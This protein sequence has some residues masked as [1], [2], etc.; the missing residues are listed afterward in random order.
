MVLSELGHQV[1]VTADADFDPDPA[2]ILWVYG[3]PNW[4]PR[5]F[6]C[7]RRCPPSERP[8]VLSWFSEPLPQ[9]RAAG[10]PRAR[11]HAREIAK[12]ILRDSRATDVYSNASRL[13]SLVRRDQLDLL[14]VSTPG[15]Q[16][17]LAERGIESSVVPLGYHRSK[18]GEDLEIERDLDVIFLGAMV[19]RRKKLLS[20]LRRSGIDVTAVGSWHDPALW[21]E[22]RTR[23]LSRTRIFL[24]LSRHPGELA[25][26]RFVLGMSAGCLVLSEPVYAPGPFVPGRHFVTSEPE[27]MPDTIR[28]Y[29]EHE[30]ECKRIAAEGHRLVTV[31][32]TAESSVERILELIDRE[33]VG[34]STSEPRRAPG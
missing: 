12:I 18:Y 33:L 22:A 28:H 14:V 24:N 29:L 11:L 30:Q 1:T 15:R 13:E 19:P 10:Q 20:S 5:I 27:S 17:F 26:G 32:L 25:G 16:E 3:N 23:L 31:S 2:S 4:F 9:P 7:L 6:G 21:G 8:F 34:R